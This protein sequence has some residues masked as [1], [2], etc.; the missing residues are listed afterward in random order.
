MPI[1]DDDFQ[2]DVWRRAIEFQIDILHT[3]LSEVEGKTEATETKIQAI[4]ANTSEVVTILRDWKGA[5]SVLKFV[6]KIAVPIGAIATAVAAV[7]GL[8]KLFGS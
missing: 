3:R 4:D 1:K 7:W 8:F 6:S 5:M 2:L